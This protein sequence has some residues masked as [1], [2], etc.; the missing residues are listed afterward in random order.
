MSIIVVN[1][2]NHFS[3]SV[4]VGWF[5]RSLLSQSVGW[6]IGWLVDWLV[7]SLAD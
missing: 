6:M 2:D 7:V 5:V 4:E 3:Y 1:S